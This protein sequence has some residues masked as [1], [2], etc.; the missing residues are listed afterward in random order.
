MEPDA[1]EAAAA[2]ENTRQQ[3]NAL[4]LAVFARRMPETA[5]P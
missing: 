5:E 4:A 3:F 1:V 2:A